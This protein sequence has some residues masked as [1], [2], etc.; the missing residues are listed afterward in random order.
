MEILAESELP[1]D[2]LSVTVQLVAS[3]ILIGPNVPEC[4]THLSKLVRGVAKCD[5]GRGNAKEDVTV[6]LGFF[7]ELA[8]KYS[9]FEHVRITACMYIIMMYILYCMHCTVYIH[10]HVDVDVSTLCIIPEYRTFY[11]IVFDTASQLSNTAKTTMTLSLQ[12]L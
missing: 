10:V 1:S 11:Q 5:G 4:H 3:L 8:D 12:P 7:R 6:V 2:V 9:G